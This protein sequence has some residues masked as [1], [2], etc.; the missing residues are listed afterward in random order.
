MS[1]QHYRI[2]MDELL[3]HYRSGDFT[4]KGTLRIYFRIRLAQGWQ[5]KIK[6]AQVREFFS[7]WSDRK[8]KLEPMSKTS[9]WRAMHELEEE[10]EIGFKEPES[11]VVRLFQKLNTVPNLEQP[12]QKRNARPENGTSI[13]NLVQEFQ[14]WDEQE[15][16]PLPDKDSS[17][18]SNSSQ[19]SY[20]FLSEEGEENFLEERI[21]WAEQQNIVSANFKSSAITVKPSV[22][23]PFS[24]HSLEKEK[25]ELLTYAGDDTPWLNPPRRRSDINFKREFMEWQGQRWMQKFSKQD[26][27]EAIADFRSSLLNNPDKIPGRWEEYENHI[28]HHASNI[29]I[30]LENGCEIAE[31]EQQKM[32]VHLPQIARPLSLAPSPENSSAYQLFVSEEISPEEQAANI[33]KLSEMMKGI[34]STSASQKPEKKPSENRIDRLNRML[35]DKVLRG[36]AMREIMAAE[37]LKVEFDENNTPYLAAEEFYDR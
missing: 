30:R 29:Q 21:E 28:L 17:T 35:A 37:D 20:K 16:E 6:P 13:P 23:D 11:L 36:E 9:F 27:H 19:I 33:K 32:I 18:S 2:A 24:A 7:K 34:G 10:G 26:I 25:H 8:G 31:A 12:P 4:A 3:T 14:I 1:Q 15:P 22:V 5:C